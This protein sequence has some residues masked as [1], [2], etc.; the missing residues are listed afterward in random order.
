LIVCVLED[1]MS[2]ADACIGFLKY[3]NFERHLSGHTLAAY[4]QDLDEFERYVGAAALLADVTGQRLLDYAQHLKSERGLAPATVKRRLACLRAMFGWLVRKQ[5]L[6]ASP[7]AT[8]ELRIAMPTRLPRCLGAGEIAALLGPGLSVSSTTRLAALLMFAT[9]MRVSELAALRLGDID[10]ATGNIRIVGKG[11]RE[12]YVFLPDDDVAVEIR[13]YV[14]QLRR[15]ASRDERLLVNA[16]GRP[17]TAEC[18]RTRI[19]SLGQRAKLARRVTPH[20]LRHSAATSLLEAGVDMRFVQ[21]LLGHRSI[22]T[23]ELYTHVSDRALK[24]AVTSANTYRAV[25]KGGGPLPR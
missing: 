23:T 22:T 19:V 15:T 12:R 17:A 3:C 1:V 2:V 20:M 18:L 7:F 21:R 11:N 8:V 4:R 16:R 6:A 9:G 24:F 5:Q 13:G 14:E 25:V 10:L